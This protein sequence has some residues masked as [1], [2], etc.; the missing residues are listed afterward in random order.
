MVELVESRYRREMWRF[1]WTLV[2]LAIAAG[3]LVV[4]IATALVNGYVA[5]VELEALKGSQRIEQTGARVMA[6]IDATRVRTFESEPSISRP[7][8]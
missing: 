4:T 6:E 8:E 3:G 2:G 1:H 5:R 7:S